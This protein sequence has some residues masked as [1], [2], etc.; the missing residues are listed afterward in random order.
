[1]GRYERWIEP[2]PEQFKVWRLA[3]DL[4]LTDKYTLGE[5]C[6]ELHARGFRY[7]TGRPFVS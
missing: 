2:D 6:E 4:L 7:R 5:I 1:M 3:W